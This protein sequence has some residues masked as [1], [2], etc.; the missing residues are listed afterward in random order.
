MA[1]G[2]DRTQPAQSHSTLQTTAQSFLSTA[3]QAWNSRLG[4]VSQLF[5]RGTNFQVD[6]NNEVKKLIFEGENMLPVTGDTCRFTMA[7]AMFNQYERTASTGGTHPEINRLLQ[8]FLR[9]L[10]G[11]IGL[12]FPFFILLAHRMYMFK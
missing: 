1:E 9:C 5:S 6:V 11:V 2:G 12:E 3:Q 4:M 7:M 10:K 8:D